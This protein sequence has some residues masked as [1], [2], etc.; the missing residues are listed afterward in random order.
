M[1]VLA[2]L[3]AGRLWALCRCRAVNGTCLTSGVQDHDRD[4]SA[5]LLSCER[6]VDSGAAQLHLLQ[7]DAAMLNS[8]ALPSTASV[9]DEPCD[10]TR[11]HAKIWCA[12]RYHIIAMPYLERLEGG[13]R[14]PRR[15]FC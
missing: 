5:V 2:R 11:H 12:R 14:W 8:D 9:L 4:R 3:A 1:R 6:L 7:E 10:Q 13:W 15:S